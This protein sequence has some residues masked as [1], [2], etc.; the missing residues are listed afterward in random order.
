MQFTLRKINRFLLIKLPSA[1]FTGV[2]VTHIEDNIA[3][4]K[5]K[6]R[7][8]SQNPFNS[9][10]YGVQS[11][12]AELSTGIL[13][14]KKIYATG[15]P[16]SMLVTKQAAEFTKKGRGVVSFTCVDGK[17][18]DQVIADTIKT[19]EGQTVFLQSE[20]L[21]EKGEIVSSFDFEWSIRVKSRK[22]KVKG[23]G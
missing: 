10:Y 7:W 1:Y 17:K 21:N 23:E 6:H 4:V 9:L 5:V 16:I 19:G 13:V 15:K 11:M 2:R 20:A 12:A 22:L 14:M 8:I 18:I 3:V